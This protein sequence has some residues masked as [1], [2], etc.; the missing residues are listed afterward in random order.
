MSCIRENESHGYTKIERRLA[1][2]GTCFLTRLI[3][4]GRSFLNNERSYQGLL[5][6]DVSFITCQPGDKQVVIRRIGSTKK[7]KRIDNN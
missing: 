3:Y 7:K 5:Q 2:Y 1:L 6:V 4:T